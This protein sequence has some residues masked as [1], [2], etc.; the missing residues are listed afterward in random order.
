[1]S[2][3]TTCFGLVVHLQEDH[4]KEVQI[5]LTHSQNTLQ[6]DVWTMTVATDKIRP[7]NQFRPTPFMRI[8]HPAAI[9]TALKYCW[10]YFNLLAPELFF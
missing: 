10:Q 9:C 2:I 7:D 3:S 1:M 5:T 4:W 6:H 8:R